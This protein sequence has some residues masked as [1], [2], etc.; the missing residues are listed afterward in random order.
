[1]EFVG[2][3]WITNLSII[4]LCKSKGADFCATGE[5]QVSPASIIR[6][7]SSINISCIL[8]GSFYNEC[9]AQQL[10]I[11]ES[12]TRQLFTVQVSANAITA[13]IPK[14]ETPKSS[15]A[16]KL[17]CHTEYLICG[18]DI[19]AGNPPDQPRNLECIQKGRVGDVICT[20]DAGQATHIRTKTVL[21]FRNESHSFAASATTAERSTAKCT[22]PRKMPE[23]QRLGFA[24]ES[25]HS[26]DPF[27]TYS[28]WVTASNQLGY[29]SSAVMN[30]TLDEIVKPNAPTFS[31]IEFNGSTSFISTIYWKDGQNAELFE[32]WYQT[33]NSSK[34]EKFGSIL[35]CFYMV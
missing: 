29:Q 35:H 28:V 2:I 6:L 17:L 10:Y 21:W 13:H 7:G 3:L 20:W 15:F 5:M 32:I 30:F 26:F 31:G 12:N 11:I 4:L 34:W 16:C 9:A 22:K 14:F 8:K 19:K 1:M 25:G 27:S 23:H 24:C 33:T 18:I